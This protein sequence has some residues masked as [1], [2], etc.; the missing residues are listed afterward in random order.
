M[1]YTGIHISNSTIGSVILLNA[2]SLHTVETCD[3][4]ARPMPPLYTL[5]QDTGITQISRVVLAVAGGSGP[6]DPPGRRRAWYPVI[7]AA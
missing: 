4:A 3:L 6:Q 7:F 5:P 2:H 1:P